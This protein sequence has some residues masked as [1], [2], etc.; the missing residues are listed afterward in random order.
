MT[1][2]GKGVIQPLLSIAYFIA[3]IVLIIASTQSKYIPIHACLVGV[4]NIIASCGVYWRRKWTYHIL[5][6]ISLIS[7]VFGFSTLA[8]VINTFSQ[9]PIS[10]LTFMG[11]VFYA[12][13]STMMLAYA[14]TQKS[15]PG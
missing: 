11:I 15:K 9:N 2:K 6:F 12:I 3:G 4:L 8:A 1:E 5:V 7:I 13:L 14:I 10:I